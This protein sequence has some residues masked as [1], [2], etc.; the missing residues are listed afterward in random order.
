[1]NASANKKPARAV[2]VRVFHAW[3][4]LVSMAGRRARSLTFHVSVRLALRAAR[5][6]FLDLFFGFLF[7]NPRGL[8]DG[9]RKLFPASLDL[10]EVVVGELPPLLLDLAFELLPVALDGIP[11]HDRTPILF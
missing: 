4:A 6:E 11:I 3:T 5:L 10:V 2:P 7:R 1:M 8:L 9:P